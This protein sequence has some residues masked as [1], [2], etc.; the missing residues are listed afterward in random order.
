MANKT[1]NQLP[2]DTTV[3]ATDKFA[4]QEA[5]GAT[6]NVTG[7]MIANYV[8]GTLPT[9]P[10]GDN[11]YNSDGTLEADRTVEID[12]KSLTLHNLVQVP[13]GGILVDFISFDIGIEY[14]SGTI[15][16][17]TMRGTSYLNVPV[18]STS[19]SGTGAIFTMTSNGTAFTIILPGSS[20]DNLT[21]GE[22][23][24][25]GDTITVSGAD[26]A[27]DDGTD[28]VILTVTAIT[29][30]SVQELT[31]T[32]NRDKIES[33]YEGDPSTVIPYIN[34]KT[35]VDKTGEIKES[36]QMIAGEEGFKSLSGMSPDRIV[37]TL[38]S[39]NPDEMPDYFDF[40]FNQDSFSY[41]GNQDKT[42]PFYRFF[43]MNQ[44]A[45]GGS[46]GFQQF[47]TVSEESRILSFVE[48]DGNAVLSS[49]YSGGGESSRLE[50]SPKS[51]TLISNKIFNVNSFGANKVM[52]GANVFTTD[53]TPTVAFSHSIQDYGT[54]KVTVFGK[55]YTSEEAYFGF[56]NASYHLLSSTGF[57]VEVG[58][59]DK[60]EKSDFPPTLTSSIAINGANIEVS[61]VGLPADSI[62]WIINIEIYGSN[63]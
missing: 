63:L 54:Y 15:P 3:V 61:V 25:V 53:D 30:P 20:P 44:K 37:H 62:D 6:K 10:T 5:G 29:D 23:Y 21:Q 34:T 57:P 56:L 46:I 19:G 26:L 11:I 16:P 59:T 4:I 9:P 43:Y 47:I 7:Q 24:E 2:A 14:T 1:I 42:L 27:G 35:Y 60:T 39:T 52:Y 32:I 49:G 13:G 33:K 58:T 48:C 55:N 38:I 36:T 51:S 8:A 18:K 41:W 17:G 12:N 28:D 50:V 31:H 22:G 45:N 40:N